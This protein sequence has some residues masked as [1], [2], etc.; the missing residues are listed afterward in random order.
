M[1]RT[2][3]LG[4]L[5]LLLVPAAQAAI[6][7]DHAY[8]ATLPYQNGLG[9]ESTSFSLI[10]GAIDAKLVDARGPYGF[11]QSDHARLGGLTR[12]CYGSTCL[13]SPGGQ[14]AIDVADGGSFGVRFPK[15]TSAEAHADH[16]LALLADFGGKRDLNTFSM[17]KTLMAPAI[18]GR[19]AF[20]Q[21]PSIPSTSG[22]PDAVSAHPNAG[23]LVALDANTHLQVLDGTQVKATLGKQ[24]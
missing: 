23:G 12:V 7:G 13:S 5:A 15:P 16:V 17:G 3:L 1:H 21:L 9:P 19:F 14:L 20:T 10:S 4:A 11:L 6:N 24:D 18:L 8:A 22:V 2:V